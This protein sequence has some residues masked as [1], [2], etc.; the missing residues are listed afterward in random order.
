D[1]WHKKKH[2]KRRLVKMDFLD[3]ISNKLQDG[4]TMHIATDWENYAE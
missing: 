3:L 2:H 4:G 1:P